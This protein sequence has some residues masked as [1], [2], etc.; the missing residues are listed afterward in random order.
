[1]H[2]IDIT[3]AEPGLNEL[4]LVPDGIWDREAI[5]MGNRKVKYVTSTTKRSSKGSL[6]LYWRLPTPDGD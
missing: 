6:I 1:M 2:W 3:T 5:Y 4:I